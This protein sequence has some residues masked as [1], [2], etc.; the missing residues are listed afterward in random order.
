MSHES[1][2]SGIEMIQEHCRHAMK[3]VAATEGT[4]EGEIIPASREQ[5]LEALEGCNESM[6]LAQ[7]A[8]D[9]LMPK[10]LCSCP[11][12][13]PAQEAIIAYSAQIY[14]ATRLKV[15][16]ERQLLAMSVNPT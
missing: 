2:G 1:I 15:A 7:Q 6:R 9:I 3:A 10:S 8:V 5:M 4:V 12:H 16:L 13:V 11:C 14:L